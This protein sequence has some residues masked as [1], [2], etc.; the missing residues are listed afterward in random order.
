MHIIMMFV[1]GAIVGIL[2]R[3][4][5]PGAVHMGLLASA[6]LGIAGSFLAGFAGRAL[7]PATRDQPFH[8]AGF[9]YSIIGAIVLIFVGRALHIIH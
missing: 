7:T 9:V 5:Y 4:F 3:F 1:V 6:L 8:P 2:A